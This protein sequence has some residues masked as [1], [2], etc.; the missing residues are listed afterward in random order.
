MRSPQNCTSTRC[1]K[2]LSDHEQ[3]IRLQARLLGALIA[4]GM[5]RWQE[6]PPVEGGRR[7]PDFR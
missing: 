5:V 4:S 7:P 2:E 6:L 3:A 1:S